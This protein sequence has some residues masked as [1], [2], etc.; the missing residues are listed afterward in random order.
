MKPKS[1]FVFQALVA[2]LMLTG[3]FFLPKKGISQSWLST[4][5]LS[6]SNASVATDVVANLVYDSNLERYTLSV[7]N[8]SRKKLKI[9]FYAGGIKYVYRASLAKFVKPFDMNGADDGIYTFAI[10]DGKALLKKDVEIKTTLIRKRETIF[11]SR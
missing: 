4:Y 8:P 11:A 10:Q 9:F 1:R 3:L 6:S 2:C 7:I 5:A